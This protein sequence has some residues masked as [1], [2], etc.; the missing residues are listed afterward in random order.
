MFIPV[1]GFLYQDLL[2][3]RVG[4]LKI[5]SKDLVSHAYEKKRND[6]ITNE[7]VPNAANYSKSTAQLKSGK[8]D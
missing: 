3:S 6:C 7:F 8:I 2:N 1:D 5:N 4:S